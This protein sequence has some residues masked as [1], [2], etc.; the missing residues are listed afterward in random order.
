MSLEKKI[1]SGIGLVTGCC[2]CFTFLMGIILILGL[3]P[4]SVERIEE[5]EV[6]IEHHT[7]S[8]EVN[9]DRVFE[10]GIYTLEPD[11]DM[12]RYTRILQ[13]IDYLNSAGNSIHCAT[14]E[15]LDMDLDIT[16][17]F[18]ID[19]E[20]LFDIFDVYGLEGDYRNFLQSFSAN[21]LKNVCGQF[22]GQDFFERRGEIEQAFIAQLQQDYLTFDLG[23]DVRL[24][25]L[26][27]VTHPSEYVTANQEREQVLQEL[28]RV[29]RLRTQQI[30][31]AQTEQQLASVN[32]NILIIQAQGTADGVL[33]QAQIQADAER[34]RWEERG[35]A[36]AAVRLA[37]GNDTSDL[38][39]VNGYVGYE[40][41][42]NN[43]NPITL[44]V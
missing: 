22:N 24:I 6:G 40:T 14:N 31:E 10:Q 30:T 34:I 11:S 15:G 5:S 21:S 19:I 9:R 43:Q 42:T 8:R 41:L 27:S 3:V 7:V 35:S 39:F 13:R 1:L 33:N 18:Q 36:L 17:Q 44:T 38:D 16:L 32:A 29:N 2:L 37:L 4:A 28:E 23:S 20:R 26:R 12:Y 25:Q